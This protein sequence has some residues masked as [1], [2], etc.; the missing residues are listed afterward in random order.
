[1]NTL[2]SK[3]SI[4]FGI[5][6]STF[7]MNFLPAN[8]KSVYEGGLTNPKSLSLTSKTTISMNTGALVVLSAVFQRFHLP[9]N[10]ERNISS[11]KSLVFG[12]HPAIPINNGDCREAFGTSCRFRWFLNSSVTRRPWLEIGIWSLYQK[13]RLGDQERHGYKEKLSDPMI[14]LN[15]CFGCKFPLTDKKWIVQPFLGVAFPLVLFRPRGSE[16]FGI[17]FTWSGLG[18]C[19]VF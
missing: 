11:N 1:M 5:L 19:Y 14:G 15:F 8:C 6:L 3:F 4:C 13:N 7:F 17:P 12:I 2:T 9:V 16:F 10:I 18:I